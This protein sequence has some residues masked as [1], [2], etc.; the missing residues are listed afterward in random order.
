[1]IEDELVLQVDIV[2]EEVTKKVTKKYQE[3]LDE[4]DRIIHAYKLRLKNVPE[5]QIAAETGLS[6][7]EIHAL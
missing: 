4:K 5:E 2:A 3:K 1:M 6:I 7:E